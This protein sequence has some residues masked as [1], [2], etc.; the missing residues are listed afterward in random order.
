MLRGDLYNPWF[1]DDKWGFEI[2]TGDFIGIVIQVDKMDIKEDGSGEVALDYH[3]IKQP[4]S[5]GIEA[6]DPLLTNTIELI[7]NDILKEAISIHEHDRNSN[8]QEL[9]S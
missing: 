8:P 6:S 4:E 5:Q 9:S 7:I 1:V 2:L 3:V